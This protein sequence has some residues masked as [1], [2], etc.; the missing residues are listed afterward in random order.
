MSSLFD[1]EITHLLLARAAGGK[2][3]PRWLNEGTD[4]TTSQVLTV[5]AS[6]TVTV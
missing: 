5:N 3:V 1:V 6:H 2:L 4:T